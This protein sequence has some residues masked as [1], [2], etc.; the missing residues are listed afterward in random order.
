VDSDQG[1]LAS[2]AQPGFAAPMLAGAP[3][4]KCNL[5]DKLCPLK[6]GCPL[7]SAQ[8]SATYQSCESTAPCKEKK[9]CFLKTFFHKAT[10][11]G[12]GCECVAGGCDTHG[13]IASPQVIKPTSQW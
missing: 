3:G 4:K 5:L 13:V 7:P 11:P 10:C 1:F 2:S 8:T 12:K 6:K 9:P